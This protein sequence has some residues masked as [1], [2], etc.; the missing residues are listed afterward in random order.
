MRESLLA[1]IQE[2]D[3]LQYMEFLAEWEDRFVLEQNA[4]IVTMEVSPDDGDYVLIRLPG[5]MEGNRFIFDEIYYDDFHYYSLLYDDE[6]DMGG[7][8]MQYIYNGKIY[9][10][11]L[12]N[13]TEKERGGP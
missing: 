3:T 1:A 12:E 13:R 10:M 4:L 5:Q 11:E 2:K 6:P 8:R 7:N 9:Y